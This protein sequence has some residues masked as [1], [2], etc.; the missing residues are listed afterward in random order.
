VKVFKKF[1]KLPKFEF[2]T[3]FDPGFFHKAF[4]F[5]EVD[6]EKETSESKDGDYY[7]P[8]QG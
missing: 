3:I 8:R 5:L 4:I 6:K 7:L 2:G 1:L